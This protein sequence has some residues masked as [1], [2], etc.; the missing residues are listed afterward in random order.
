MNDAARVAE[1]HKTTPTIIC[2][3]VHEIKFIPLCDLRE[4]KDCITYL[5]E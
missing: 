2:S 1:L 3:L 4:S 5:R